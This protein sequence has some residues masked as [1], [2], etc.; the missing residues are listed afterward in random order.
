MGGGDRARQPKGP[1]FPTAGLMVL[2]R[3]AWLF[4]EKKLKKPAADRARGHQ[5]R[6]LAAKSTGK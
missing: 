2:D 3:G 5:G 1:A 6:V 4:R